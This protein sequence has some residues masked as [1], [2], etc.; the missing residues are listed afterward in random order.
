[1]GASGTAGATTGGPHG[2]P[3]AEPRPVA[4]DA[5][6][7]RHPDERKVSRRSGLLLVG[8]LVQAAFGYALLGFADPTGWVPDAHLG[9][10]ILIVLVA[11]ALHRAVRRLPWE[12]PR[13]RLLAAV[14]TLVISLALVQLLTGLILRGIVPGFMLPLSGAHLMLGLLTALLIILA[15]FIAIG[16]SLLISAR[17]QQEADRAAF[18]E[19]R[20]ARSRGDERE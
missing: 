4:D 10:G 15:H 6:R 18:E 5:A 14:S 3:S 12:G 13:E 1:M 11:V 7:R 16:P 19:G 17:R 8:I 2:E 9:I 20:K